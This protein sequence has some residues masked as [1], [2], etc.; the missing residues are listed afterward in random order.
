MY[1]FRNLISD[2]KL[3]I[4]ISKSK[5]IWKMFQIKKFL[6][7]QRLSQK[8]DGRQKL[9]ARAKTQFLEKLLLLFDLQVPYY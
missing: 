1:F 9:D 6:C 7:D 3:F 4:D 8:L 2:R 5:R